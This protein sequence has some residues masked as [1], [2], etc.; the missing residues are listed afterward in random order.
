MLR[1]QPESGES[2]HSEG[3]STPVATISWTH[4]KVHNSQSQAQSL[5]DA[6]NLAKQN[7]QKLM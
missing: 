1:S 7:K 4:F 2:P 5:A 6:K 3:A